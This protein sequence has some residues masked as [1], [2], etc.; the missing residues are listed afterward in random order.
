MALKMKLPSRDK[1][2]KKQEKKAAPRPKLDLAAQFRGADWRNPATMPAAPKFVLYCLVAAVVVFVVWLLLVRDQLTTLESK[3]QEEEKYRAEFVEKTTKV[4][5][6][7]PL[8]E[9]KQQAEEHVAQLEKQLPG[10]SEMDSLLSDINQAGVGRSLQFELFKPGNEEIK[11]YY[12]QLPV[13][14]RVSGQFSDIASFAA[15]IAHLSRIVTLS[16][17]NIGEGKDKNKVG[18]L[19]MEATANTFRY[20]DKTEK[21]ANAQKAANANKGAQS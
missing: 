17:M 3:Q 10:K 19:V 16:N 1:R 8:L 18:G 11:T 6:L 4:A 21:A 2:G 12:A 9:Q 14:I 13:A 15:D 5:N 7:E 20:L